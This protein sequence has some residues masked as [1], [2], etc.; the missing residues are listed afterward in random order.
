MKLN[1]ANKLE[2]DF[3]QEC[4]KIALAELLKES[5]KSDGQIGE[6][7]E[8]DPDSAACVADNSL[9]HLRER[10]EHP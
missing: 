3:W 6:Y 10:L 4:Y 2:L 5:R 9:V 8:S 1:P 7:T